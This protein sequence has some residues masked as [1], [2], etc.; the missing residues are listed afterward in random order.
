MLF[1]SGVNVS[2]AESKCVDNDDLNIVDEKTVGEF[3]E[4]LDRHL[5]KRNGEMEFDLTGTDKNLVFTT[6]FNQYKESYGIYWHLKV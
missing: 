4:N 3:L 6:H 2:V 1:R 5:V